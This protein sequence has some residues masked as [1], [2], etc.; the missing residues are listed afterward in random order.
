MLTNLIAMTCYSTNEP[1]LMEPL[2]AVFDKTRMAGVFHKLVS[3]LTRRSYRLLDLNSYP[4][5]KVC[6]H[7]AGE[8]EVSLADIRGTEG[9]QNDFDDQFHPLSDRT[10]ERWLSAARANEEGRSL[11]PV[12]LIQV[13]EVYFV[14]D[15]H[16]RVSVAR[17]FGQTTIHARVTIWEV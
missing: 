1:F 9:R 10:R 5:E 7:D 3:I 13:G 4:T 2:A 16:H 6:G 11:P 17:T 15:G 14:R 8:R 12:E